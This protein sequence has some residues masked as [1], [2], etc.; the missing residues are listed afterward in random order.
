M[1]QEQLSKLFGSLSP[2]KREELIRAA[3]GLLKT[4]K[5][6]EVMRAIENDPSLQKKLK[7][8]QAKGISKLTKADRDRL[9]KAL[10][11]FGGKQKGGLR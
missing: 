3:N 9:L 6:Q 8:A 4:Q 11:N 10:G 1:N 2:D 7:E 5:G